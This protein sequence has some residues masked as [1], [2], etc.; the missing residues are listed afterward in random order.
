MLTMRIVIGGSWDT[1]M[2]ERPTIRSLKHKLK[3]H[4]QDIKEC[5]DGANVGRSLEDDAEK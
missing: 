2:T 3:V 5:D 1:T 4:H